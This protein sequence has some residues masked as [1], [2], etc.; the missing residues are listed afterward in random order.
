MA[1]K[2]NEISPLGIENGPTQEEIN[3]WK[4]KFGDV[5]VATFGNNEKY[6]YRPLRRFEYKQILQVNQGT[7]S[8]T[9]A[10]EK[11][12]QM[13]VVWPKLDPTKFTTLKAGTISTLVDL[14]MAASNFGINEEPVK[15]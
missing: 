3:D 14:I 9:F 1:E 10:E 6:V 5:Y 4:T 11:V 13:C 8:R 2:V 15:L 7:E 12:A